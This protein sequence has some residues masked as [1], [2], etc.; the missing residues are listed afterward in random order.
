MS[1]GKLWTMCLLTTALVS[2]K[3]L[4]PMA[5]REQL[6]IRFCVKDSSRMLYQSILKEKALGRDRLPTRCLHPKKGFSVTKSAFFI[7]RLI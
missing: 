6:L 4:T 5:L 1:S 2:A 3:G 7:T